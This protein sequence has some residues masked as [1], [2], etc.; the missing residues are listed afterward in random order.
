MIFAFNERFV[1]QALE[2]L[3]QEEL[4]RAPTTHNN[5]LLW[6][7]GHLSKLERLWEAGPAFH[8]MHHPN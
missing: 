3:T 1:I 4:W 8:R 5:P 6:V 7:A 2:G